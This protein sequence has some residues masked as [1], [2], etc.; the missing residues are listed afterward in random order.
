MYTVH[1]YLFT[2][3]TCTCTVYMHIHC[4]KESCKRAC[5]D[6]QGLVLFGN[7]LKLSPVDR[8]GKVQH[9]LT[10]VLEKNVLAIIAA[11]AYEIKHFGKC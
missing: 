5:T 4:R 1:L 9:F 3:H 11:P 8:D 2:V 6:A 7:K 10:H